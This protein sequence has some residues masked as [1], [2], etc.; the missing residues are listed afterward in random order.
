MSIDDTSI[1]IGP[2]TVAEA[3]DV[4]RKMPRDAHIYTD[5]N[6]PIVGIEAMPGR[7]GGAFVVMLTAVIS[8]SAA[9]IPVALAAGIVAFRNRV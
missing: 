2:M 9:S 3:I 5:S 6:D 7:A 4:L 8:R 1:V